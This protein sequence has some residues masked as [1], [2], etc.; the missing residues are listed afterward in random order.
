MRPLRHLPLAAALVAAGAA[1]YWLRTDLRT[2]GEAYPA[3]SAFSTAP[4]GCSLA[5]RYAGERC[6]SGAGVLARPVGRAA[7]GP[8]DVVL[9]IA[10]DAEGGR[11]GGPGADDGGSAR[12]PETFDAKTGLARREEEW[13]R[14]GGRLVLA[15]KGD[16]R[17]FRVRTP[18]GSRAL[19]K[20]CPVWPEVARVEPERARSLAGEPVSSG[21][22]LFSYGEDPAVA[23]V[24]LGRGEVVA[25]TCPEVFT[26][27]ALG[28]ADHLA[29]LDAV[30]SGRE[31]AHF[32]EYSHGMQ[33][34]AGPAELLRRWG[35]GPFLALLGAAAAAHFLR[36][37]SGVGPPEDDRVETRT[38]TVD[39]VDSL[40]RLYDRALTRSEAAHMYF[41]ALTR[42]C[43][44]A[45][46]LRG[47][48]LEGKVAELTG[49]LALHPDTVAGPETA[50]RR[51]DVGRAEFG[52]DL[53]ALNEAF[54]RLNDARRRRS[55]EAV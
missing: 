38:E 11:A 17:S 28:A 55:R 53:T 46:G 33:G 34:A 4:E 13:V 41:Q 47:K 32:D 16:Y 1:L 48:A 54:R 50:V 39:F 44:A 30:I 27:S 31:R 24:P 51:R 22:A 43:A 49:G 26:N 8:T 25:L 7:L 12:P 35:L 6:P 15:L 36:A 3:F 37:R 2:S 29:L 9:R 10:P 42:S 20:S 45:T 14:A 52:A 21:H 40:A 19:G 5:F 18:G 23:R